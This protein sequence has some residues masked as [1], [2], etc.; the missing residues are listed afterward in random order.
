MAHQ[1]G[2]PLSRVGMRTGEGRR[3]LISPL[4]GTSVRLLN[5]FP[6]SLDENGSAR[7]ES[8]VLLD[9]WLP[10]SSVEGQPGQGIYL[11]QDLAVVQLGLVRP[12]LS[13]GQL[14]Q[15]SGSHL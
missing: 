8:K 15:T 1:D 11:E 13:L 12:S 4:E 10:A 6:G 2:V 14:R 9:R 3:A 7:Q 5:D